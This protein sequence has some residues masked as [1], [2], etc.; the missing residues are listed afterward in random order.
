ME[1]VVLVVVRAAADLAAAGW[2][3]ADLAAGCLGAGQWEGNSDSVGGWAAAVGL[4]ARQLAPVGGQVARWDL[5]AAALMA[6][7]E[8]V[9][10]RVAVGSAA[11]GEVV[12]GSATATVAV[13]EMEAPA[14]GQGAAAGAA[15]LPRGREAAAE[16]VGG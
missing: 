4:L 1:G 9:V 3:A 15:A 16:E 13:A 11:V 14:D 7:V 8:W 6:A 2:A 5:L 12:V 10:A